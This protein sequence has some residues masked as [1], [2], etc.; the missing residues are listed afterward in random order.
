MAEGKF[1]N[2]RPH[3][4]EERQIEQAF[5]QVTGQEPVPQA[6]GPVLSEED[7]IAQTIREVRQQPAPKAPARPPVAPRKPEGYDLLPD[8]VDAFFDAE[9]PDFDQDSLAAEPDFID[10]AADFFRKAV[11]Y[12]EKNQKFVMAGACIGALLIIVSFI[13]LFFAG[14]SGGS[15]D[16]N[17]GKILDNVI[18]ADV[19]V[20][21]LTKTEAISAVKLATSATYT[22][23]D[24]VINLSGIE[25]RLTPKDTKAE[26]D[27]KAAVNAAYDYGRTGTKA[28]QAQALENSRTEQHIIGLLPYLNLNTTYIKETLSAYATESGS[29]LTQA[30]HKLEGPAP[31][32]SAEKFDE[33]APTQTLVITLGTPGIGFDVNSV[34]DQVL[35]A[36][37]LHRFLVEVENVET[38]RDPDPVDLEAIYKEYYIEPVNAT[39]DLQNFK[40]ESGSYGYGFDL[41]AAQKL[42]DKAE[43]GQEV[44][45]PMEYIPPELL[46]ADS[47]LKDTLGEYRTRTTGNDDRNKNLSL[48]CQAIHG[49]VLDPGESLDFRSALSKVSGFRVAPQDTG[50]EDAEKG[51][52]T[53]VASTLYYAALLSD[54]SVPSRA[55]HD[56]VPSFIEPGLD[57]TESLKITN[58]TGFPIRIEAE[59]S[60]GYV[61]VKIIGTEERSHYIGLD[62]TISNT[63]EPE[64]EYQDFAWDNDEGYQDGDVIE[65]GSAGYLVKSYKIKYSTESG[66]ELSRD[67]IANSQYPGEVKIIARV[68][69]EPT[70][71]PT[72]PIT[73]PP[74]E[75]TVP[76]TEAPKPTEPKPTEPP[77]TQ[78]PEPT[79]PQETVPPTQAPT[80]PPATQP[81]VETE[82]TAPP[83][84]G[85]EVFAPQEDPADAPENPE[86]E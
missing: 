35:D 56:F 57:A 46:S 68:E 61:K 65:E 53:Q 32:L 49:T 64:V 36:Y 39:V 84:Y 55:N 51:G 66:K 27:V 9:S 63:Y 2:P 5:R 31:A 71:E 79:V 11:T 40:N 69:P 14:A 8:D 60:G 28:E 67:F 38:T 22:K 42:I 74:V 21:G 75:E 6:G 37:S 80:E 24:M 23:Q 45:I 3:R 7:K 62:Y 30:T 33:K 72:E 73:E 83:L 70:E 86:S 58:S 25:L 15:A 18:I 48:A 77:V 47:F 10:K 34:Y 41:E 17:D 12:C 78:P 85:E 26:L 29:T 50:R 54:L 13:G 81:P 44:R 82:P 52:V 19:N 43:F 16:P 1:S 4:D 76:P 59:V 20:G